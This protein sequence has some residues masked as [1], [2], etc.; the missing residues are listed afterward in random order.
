MPLQSFTTGD[1]AEVATMKQCEA[2]PSTE[3]RHFTTGLQGNDFKIAMSRSIS[4][5]GMAHDVFSS[6]QVGE[7]S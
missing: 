3:H 6:V 2:G 5:D 7:A 4:L 1:C